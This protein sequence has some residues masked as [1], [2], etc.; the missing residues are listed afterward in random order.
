MIYPGFIRDNDIIGVTACSGGLS[1]EIDRIRTES[2]VEEFEKRHLRIKKTENVHTDVLGRSSDGRTRAGE[3]TELA[4]NPEIKAVI[5]AK[6]GDYLAEMLPFL[7]YDMFSANPKW[8]QGYSDPTGLLFG[9]TTKCDIATLYSSNF[10]EF[11]MKPWH[12]SLENNIRI[13]KGESLVQTSF[14]HY[15][16]GFTDHVTGTETYRK[17]MPVCWTGLRGEKDLTMKGRMIGGC[18]DVLLKLV[19][20]PFEDVKGF[21]KKYKPDGIIWYMESFATDGENLTIDLWHLRQAGWFEGASGFVF[22]RPCFYKSFSG[23]TYEEAVRNALGD[24][25]VPII[26]G[27][28]VGHKKP[29]ITIING[30]VGEI[31]L[32]DGKARISMKLV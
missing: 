20:T 4:E 10:A 9:I 32:K 5:I 14:D 15:Q 1:E 3:L 29:S 6:G 31:T 23:I 11:S 22:G 2:A 21:V 8:Y 30:A 17:D 12:E 13:L 16:D 25:N 18:L 26:T 24:M 19:G 27:A 28:D 7:D